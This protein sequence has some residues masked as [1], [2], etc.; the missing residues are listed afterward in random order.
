M[1]YINVNLT[2]ALDEAQKAELSRALSQAVTCFSGKPRPEVTMVDIEDG[3]A[4]FLGDT[5][6]TAGAYV[7]VC[8][9]GEYDLAEK[10]AYTAAVTDLLSA[11]FGI[12]GNAVYLTFSE[13]PTWGVFGKQQTGLER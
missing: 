13:F 4:M 6:L 1:P 8:V 11:Q 10:D 12:P 7:N 2:A 3:K 5:P 9:H